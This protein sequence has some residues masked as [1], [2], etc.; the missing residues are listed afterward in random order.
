MWCRFYSWLYPS[1]ILPT[2]SKV[3]LYSI[4]KRPCL[5][6]CLFFHSPFFMLNCRFNTKCGSDLSVVYM[7]MS[8]CVCV[9]VWGVVHAGACMCGS[10]IKMSRVLLIYLIPL[11][12]GI[13]LVLCWQTASFSDLLPPHLHSAGVAG[14]STKNKN[15]IL[16]FVQEMFLT[17]E[18]FLQLEYSVFT[19]LGI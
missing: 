12:K 9:C 10:Y 7:S 8:L 1:G 16:T 4:S 19:S 3:L 5:F 6:I 2:D 11:D 18:Y 15:H 17:T 14:I 13:F